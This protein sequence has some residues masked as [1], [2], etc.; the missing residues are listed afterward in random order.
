MD[1]D[2][3]FY[4]RV[5][6]LASMATTIGKNYPLGEHRLTSLKDNLD[7]ISSTLGFTSGVRKVEFLK[8]A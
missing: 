7:M 1:F 6:R 4:Q 2:Q 5:K 8:V 3:V